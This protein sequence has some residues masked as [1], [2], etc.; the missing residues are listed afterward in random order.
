MNLLRMEK[1]VKYFKETEGGRKIVCK[2][3]EDLAEKR[4]LEEKKMLAKSMLLRGRGS[5]EQ[6]AEDL[7]LPIEVLEELAGLQP[8]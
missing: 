3:F 6:I 5:V 1:Q 8:V 4:L 2:A 7:E